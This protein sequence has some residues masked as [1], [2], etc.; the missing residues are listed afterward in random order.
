MPN[1]KIA[2]IEDNLSIQQMYVTKLGLSGF[3]VKAAD[4]GKAGLLLIAKYRPELIL[5]DIKMPEMSGDE[6]LQHLRATDYGWSVKVIILT[7]LSRDEA[8]R[9]LQILNI[10]RYVVKAHHTPQQIIGI[11]NDVLGITS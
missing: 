6:M 1:I 10:N 4:D 3:D 2:V 9:S 8:P 11:V 5:L 7:N